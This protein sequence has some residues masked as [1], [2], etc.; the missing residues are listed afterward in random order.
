MNKFITLSKNRFIHLNNNYFRD[1]LPVSF[2]HSNIFNSFR[3]LGRDRYSVFTRVSQ[4]RDWID[5][6]IKNDGLPP[7]P[8]QPPILG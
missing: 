4:F 7:A 2:I 6:V 5:G 1:Y 8:P 3:C